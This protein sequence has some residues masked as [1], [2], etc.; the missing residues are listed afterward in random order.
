MFTSDT[1]KCAVIRALLKQVRLD[2]LWT[3]EGPTDAAIKLLEARGGPLSHGEQLML[4]A[5]F[6]VW[7]GDGRAT[8]GELLSVLDNQNL[9]NLG[10]LLVA[11]ASPNAG[12]AVDAWLAARAGGERA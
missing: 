9:A 10:T 1:Q 5:A 4:L 6:D 11:L 12:R 2:Y 7:N 3:L 8:L